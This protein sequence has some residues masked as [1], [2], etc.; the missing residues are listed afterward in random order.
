MS[1]ITDSIIRRRPDSS[2]DV[3][4]YDGIARYLR[5]TLKRLIIPA[6]GLPPCSERSC[7]TDS[8][9]PRTSLDSGRICR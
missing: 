9:A 2:I 8:G 4:H 6:G 1:T 3:D 7:D 5:A